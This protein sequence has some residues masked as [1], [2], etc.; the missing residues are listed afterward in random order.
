MSFRINLNTGPPTQVTQDVNSFSSSLP[1][2]KETISPPPIPV[3]EDFRY[4]PTPVSSYIPPETNHGVNTTKPSSS[5]D[6]D[7]II[8]DKTAKKWKMIKESE[9]YRY[10]F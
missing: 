2:E 9:A 6:K 1:E 5:L 8:Y 4:K 10:A 3:R 7:R